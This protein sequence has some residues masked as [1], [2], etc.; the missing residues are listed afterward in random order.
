[1]AWTLRHIEQL[2][3]W[4]RESCARDRVRGIYAPPAVESGPVCYHSSHAILINN[5]RTGRKK[6]YMFAI[7]GFWPFFV[8][9]C[10]FGAGF[11]R[12]CGFGK[13]S[14][15]CDFGHFLCGYAVSGHFI[16]GFVVSMHSFLLFYRFNRFNL[17][18]SAVL[19]FLSNFLFCGFA[20]FGR[21]FC[22]FAFSATPIRPPFCSS[23][24]V[25]ASLF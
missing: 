21:F 22:G 20:V 6:V 3:G 16:C 13:T 15:V 18:F 9:L 17:H 11:L 7:C 14:A 12:F 19:R 1:M 4:G 24:K 5:Y 25:Y 2:I 8:R 23:K 10:G